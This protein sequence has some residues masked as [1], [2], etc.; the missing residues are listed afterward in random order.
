MQLG[1]KTPRFCS[2]EC[3]R[4]THARA[5]KL[6]EWCHEKP[7]KRGGTKFCS[8]DC[9]SQAAIKPDI[10][11]AHCANPFKPSRL[12]SIFCS[13]VCAGHARTKQRLCAQCGKPRNSRQ[14]K[15]CSRACA[16]LGQRVERKNC[17]SCGTQLTSRTARFCSQICYG[18]HTKV[19]RPPCKVCG[20]AI[21]HRSKGYCSPECARIA[22]FPIP[23]CVVCGADCKRGLKCCS[24][25]CRS[26]FMSAV[27][28]QYTDEFLTKLR[29][30]LA[31]GQKT[32]KEIAKEMG[33][34]HGALVGLMFRNKLHYVAP[35]RPRVVTT[36]LRTPNPRPSYRR[37]KTSTQQTQKPQ[38]A[39]PLPLREVIRL[40]GEWGINRS[41]GNWAAL[42][43]QL[44]AAVRSENPN[45][46][47]YRLA[48]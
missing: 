42:V 37:W 40:C 45:H 33:I 18:Q 19:K 38:G 47:G 30:L 23:K 31:S 5:V 27:R 26:K 44:S 21:K 9:A 43:H 25:E 28:S 15:Y 6:C 34:S 7:I 8:R 10:E 3:F 24:D 41:S 4:I 14:R 36:K 13:N 1:R 46:R 11:C 48:S 35:P 39:I 17:E 16:H 12:T 29:E 20:K 32:R 2:K 22:R